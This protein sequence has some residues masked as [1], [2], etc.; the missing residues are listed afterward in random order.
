MSAPAVDPAHLDG[1]LMR[2]GLLSS[3]ALGCE[4][5]LSDV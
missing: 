2:L 3:G 4:G 5:V 1:E